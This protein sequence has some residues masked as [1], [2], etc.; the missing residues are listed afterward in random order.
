MAT[1][2]MKSDKGIALAILFGVLA[3]AGAGVSLVGHGTEM[4]GYGF[5]VA[6]LFGTLLVAAI[7]VYD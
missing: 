5:A 4:A 1:E 6:M 3:L 2:T 7:H